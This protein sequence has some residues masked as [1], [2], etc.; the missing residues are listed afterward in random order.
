MKKQKKLIRLTTLLWDSLKRLNRSRLKQ[1]QTVMDDF[2]DKCLETTK[3]SHLF[4]TAV[5]KG[6]LIGAE[7]IRS[8]IERNLNEFSHHLQRFKELINSDESISPN[9]IDI[10]G[11]LLQIEQ[12]F[13]KLNIDFKEKTISVITEDIVLNDFSFGPFEIRLFI[14]QIKKLY[15]DSPYRIIAIEPNPAGN[16]SDVTHPHVSGEKLCEGEGHVA[17]RAAIEQGRFNDFF[18]L[19]KS[20]LQT[21]NPDSAYINL[22]DWE[23]RG[24]YDC[25]DTIS[26]DESYY[27]EKCDREYCGNCATYCKVCDTTVCL[28]CSIE[29]PDCK[30]SICTDCTNT[31]LECERRFCEDCLNKEG[32]C[33]DCEAERIENEEQHS[34]KIDAEV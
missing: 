4:N 19:V 32:L 28:G 21:Y 18:T 15:N 25:G 23:G 27:C 8:K 10:F 9:F 2:S 14:N 16:N 5:E 22:D 26:A 7:S 20:I 11:E 1:I 3:D 30:R 6:W 13:G 34:E 17:I 31:C 33:E 12:E 24:C 29:C